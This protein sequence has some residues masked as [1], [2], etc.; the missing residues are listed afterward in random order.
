MLV[1]DVDIV[2]A[3]RALKKINYVTH[4]SYSRALQK[5]NHTIEL[6]HTEH[7]TRLELHWRLSANPAFFNPVVTEAQTEIVMLADKQLRVLNKELECVYLCAHG[8]LHQWNN[9]FW[10]VD[11]N[12]LL[13]NGELNW[14]EVESLAALYKMNVPLWL[15]LVLCN[16][17][18]ETEIP[19]LRNAVNYSLVGRLAE[20]VVLDI[21]KANTRNWK[22]LV[23][24]TFYL[25]KLRGG[26]RYQTSCFI[27][28]LRRGF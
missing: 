25:M 14:N 22:H 23:K 27:L 19:Y 12:Q 4:K 2:P 21:D 11:I 28:R 1:R 13:R 3:I 9:L 18:F 10:L 7:Q 5:K 26:F 6:I 8:S 16:W 15:A 20:K 17:L 24:K